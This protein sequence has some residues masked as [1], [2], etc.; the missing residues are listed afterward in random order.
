MKKICNLLVLT[1]LLSVG[2]KAIAWTTAQDAG[3]RLGAF[4]VKEFSFEKSSSS[5]SD[6]QK[7]EIRA[8]L[9]ESAQS[10][11]I[12]EVKVLAWS[13]KEYPLDSTKQ[14]KSDIN[15]AKNRLIN[16]KKYLQD[17]LK[18]ADVDTY[19]MTKKPNALQKL[20]HTSTA[21]VKSAN[22]MALADLKDDNSELFDSKQQS[23]KAILFIFMKK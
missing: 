4:H 11:K 15:L 1:C 13:D 16:V 2:L 10:G 21:K 7:E 8:A 17:D 18:V 12:D 22:Q 14:S 20:L 19:N 5:I 3:S 6:I 23:S 9:T